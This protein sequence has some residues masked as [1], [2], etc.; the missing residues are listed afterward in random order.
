MR[1]GRPVVGMR[2]CPPIGERRLFDK[3]H[4]T[5]DDFV[6]LL[7]PVDVRDVWM[8]QRREHLRFT[9]KSREAIGIVGDGGQQHLDRDVAIQLRVVGAIDLAHAA[10][11]KQADDFIWTESRAGNER[12]GR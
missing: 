8:V 11:T 10:D 6:R 4:H 7:E 9:T 3:F 2:P 1:P 5:R 12:Q